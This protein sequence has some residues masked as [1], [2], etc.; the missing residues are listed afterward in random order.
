MSKLSLN[1]LTSSFGF[2]AA[3]NDVLDNIEKEF[4]EKVLYRDNPEGTVNVMKNDIDMGEHDLLNVGKVAAEDFS[5]KGVDITQSL[6]EALIAVAAYPEEA[7]GYRD[8]AQGYAESA[9]SQ[10]ALC[11][12]QTALASGYAS[13]ASAFAD[14]AEVAAT[15]AAGDVS[16]LLAGYV[17]SAEGYADDAEQS[18]IDAEAAVNSAAFNNMPIGSLVY[19]TSTTAASGTIAAQ[20]QLVSRSAFP[21]LWAFAQASGNISVDDASWTKGQYS[22]GD[23]STTFRVPNL[24]DQFIRGAS[25]TRAVGH[26]EEDQNKIHDHGGGSHTH[27]AGNSQLSGHG[28]SPEQSSGRNRPDGNAGSGY[29]GSTST[30]K[31][32]VIPNDGGEE[33][34]PVNVA[35]LI[36]IKAYDV[37]SDPNVLN[38]VQVVNDINRFESEINRLENE[39][40]RK[41]ENI[42]C[43]VSVAASG[44]A[45]DFVG[46]PVGV[47]RITV[48]F[49]GVSI[50]G[51]S[52]LLLRVGT[53][54]GI[55]SSGYVSNRGT[56]NNTSVFVINNTVGFDIA[57]HA[58]AAVSQRG[59]VVLS[60]I[61]GNKWGARGVMAD[62]AKQISTTAG[63]VVLTGTL[64][65]IRITTNSTDIFDAGTINISWEF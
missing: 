27:W 14:A 61:T 58:S 43:G 11:E 41:D 25:G 47:K 59:D 29:E 10:V 65:R 56:I 62:G 28:R 55:V 64:D 30:P 49:D 33:A 51:T 5:I 8:E 12:A 7:K 1:R 31:T 35:Y 60:T 48:M 40:L 53:S 9:A 17:T 23:G 45:V 42:N 38:A 13:D 18:A 16:T 26:G 52:L 20:G 63:T 36:C 57:S 4:S 46:I 15:N 54:G 2:Q 32:T 21:D 24:Q 19:V 34:R 3:F 6:E 22:P 39:K 44:T 50:S 37:I